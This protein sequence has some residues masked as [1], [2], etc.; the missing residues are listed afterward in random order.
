LDARTHPEL[1]LERAA[2][3]VRLQVIDQRQLGL[4]PEIEFAVADGMAH[5]SR[6]L[7]RILLRSAELVFPDEVAAPV[8]TRCDR[9]T[10]EQLAL[11]VIGCRVLVLPLQVD[12]GIARN[13]PPIREGPPE[14]GFALRH[15]ELAVDPVFVADRIEVD[16]KAPWQA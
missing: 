10:E 16:L 3:V 11:E 9:A 2:L 13:F 8:P 15:T 4:E 12:R 6:P 5:A 7:V 14:L 1:L